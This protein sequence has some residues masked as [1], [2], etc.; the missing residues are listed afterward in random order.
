VVIKWP[1]GSREQSSR[2]NEGRDAHLAQLG[3]ELAG[4]I[5]HDEDGQPVIR[6]YNESRRLDRAINELTGFLRA[7]LIDGS[8]DE[9]EVEALGKWLLKNRE[10]QQVWPVNV[11]TNR[12]ANLLK[13][14]I[15]DEAERAELK[16]LL[17]KFTGP[18]PDRFLDARSATRLP[19]TNPQPEVLFERRTFVFTGKF[20]YGTRKACEQEVIS[21]GGVC[22]PHVTRRTNYLI[23][24]IISSEDWIYSTHGRKIEKA[25]AFASQGHPI[26]IISEEHWDRFV[27]SGKASAAGE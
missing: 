26:A 27:M 10:L 19:V 11:I 8:V 21:R 17:E 12:V 22:E 14:G 18:E 2:P 9:S 7:I 13:H 5:A 23:I 16:E 6:A 1:F 24:G 20:L 25:V 4:E 3:R 15:T